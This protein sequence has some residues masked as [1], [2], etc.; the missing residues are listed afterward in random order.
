MENIYVTWKNEITDREWFSC[1]ALMRKM[2]MSE[3]RKLI[4]CRQVKA[5]WIAFNINGY[6]L[7]QNR[8]LLFFFLKY[9]QMK[10]FADISKGAELLTSFNL[11]VSKSIERHKQRSWILCDALAWKLLMHTF[12]FVVLALSVNAVFYVTRRVSD[13]PRRYFFKKNNKYGFSFSGSI[14][15][16]ASGIWIHHTRQST[17]NCALLGRWLWLHYHFQ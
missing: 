9:L 13:S 8:I 11:I 6:S 3:P 1:V 16:K 2:K 14:L 12:Q 4:Y 10:A 17:I 7:Q 5:A 15:L